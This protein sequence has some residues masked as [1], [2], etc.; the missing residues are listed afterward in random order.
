MVDWEVLGE[1]WWGAWLA[2]M[3]QAV[4]FSQKHCINLF[5]FLLFVKHIPKD[6]QFSKANLDWEYNA[7]K[8]SELRVFIAKLV[9][10]QNQ[11]QIR[12]QHRDSVTHPFHPLHSFKNWQ[13]LWVFVWFLHSLFS[14]CTGETR[15]DPLPE[16]L[17][18]WGKIRKLLIE[19][20]NVLSTL[21]PTKQ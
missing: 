7:G 2:F 10:S 12:W 16:G 8:R 17:Q 11:G 1:A 3:W 21:D 5:C 19:V 20:R 6:P 4:M 13:E 15:W 14:F 9:W 18:H